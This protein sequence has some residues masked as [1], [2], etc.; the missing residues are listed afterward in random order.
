MCSCVRVWL[1]VC[2]GGFLW[3]LR[4]GSFMCVGVGL[5]VWVWV[6]LLGADACVGVVGGYGLLGCG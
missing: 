1:W 4:L 3:L 2:V 6:L 5:C